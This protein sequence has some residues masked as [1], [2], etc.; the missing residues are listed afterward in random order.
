MK[1]IFDLHTTQDGVLPLPTSIS[2]EGADD[3]Y[4]A[5]EELSAAVWTALTLR[6][7]LLLTGEPGSGKTQLAYYIA[8][9]FDLG[10]V[11][12]FNA[13]TTSVKKDLFYMYDALGHFQLAQIEKEEK[14]AASDIEN[15][16]IHYQALGEAIRLA[17]TEGT[18]G[19]NRKPSIVLIDEIDKAPRDLP[20]DLLGA[21]DKLEFSVPEI[22]GS[23]PKK[24]PEK[25][26]PVII[27][28]SNSEKNLPDAFLRRVVYYHITFPDKV[29]LLEILTAKKLTGL[30][31]ADLEIMIRHF[32]AIRQDE[33]G[34]NKNP[35]TAEL[36]Q[37]AS[38]LPKLNFP[39]EKLDNTE[40]LDEKERQLLQISYGVLAKSRED[41]EALVRRISPSNQS[42]EEA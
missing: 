42:I 38:L 15:S 34:L 18:K 35:A 14:L 21:L 37:W 28:T 24:C 17:Q 5:S 29:K 32:E 6:Q 26:K 25:L 11:L 23:E 20:N 8:K 39:I 1:S 27:I 41:L 12:V 40:N 16:F 2:I 4:V 33:T 3:A 10:E 22:P 19:K 36:I 30:K 9:R 13:Q 31:K 7:P